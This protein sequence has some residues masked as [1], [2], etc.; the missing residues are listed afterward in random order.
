M[1][2]C[3]IVLIVLDWLIVRW[4]WA[5][6]VN[7]PITGVTPPPVPA[8]LISIIPHFSRLAILEHAGRR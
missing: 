3:A 7:K 1:C 4:V 6:K 5:R 8:P 2:L